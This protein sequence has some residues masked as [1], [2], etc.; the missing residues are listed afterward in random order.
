MEVPVHFFD[1]R[2]NSL[3]FTP[4]T[5]ETSNHGLHMGT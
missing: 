5:L 4:Y 3:Q 2:I 1:V